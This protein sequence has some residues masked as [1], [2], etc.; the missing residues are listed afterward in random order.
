MLSSW[1]G[2][3]LIAVMILGG[4][5]VMGASLGEAKKPAESPPPAT[6]AEGTKQLPPGLANKPENH[7]GRLKHMQH[8]N[9][10]KARGKSMRNS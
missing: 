5:C 8:A 6:S 9:P 2:R 4:L 7:P 1:S 3:L 10:G